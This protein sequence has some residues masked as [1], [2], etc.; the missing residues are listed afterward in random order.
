MYVERLCWNPVAELIPEK[1]MQKIQWKKLKYMLNYVYRNS[2]YYNRVFREKG[3]H[4][5]DINSFD[6]FYKK[7]PLTYKEDLRAMQ[8]ESYP[9]G[10]NMCVPYSEV[11][12][13]TASTGTTGKPTYTGFT[14]HDWEINKEC[15]KRTFWLAGLRPGDVY[16]HALALSNWISGVAVVEAG[17]EMGLVVLPIGVPT[18]A[19]R[20][21]TMILDQHPNAMTCTPSYALHL[22]D[23]VRELLNKDPK[24][25]GIRKM[26]C[27][28][29]PG[30]GI[31]SIRKR[32]EEAWGADVRDVMGTPEQISA[33]WA[34]CQYKCGMHFVAR[35]FVLNELVDPETK[36]HIEWG[37]GVEG[38][39]VYT[40]LDRECAPLIR[41]YVA[42]QV[43]AFTEKCECGYP[44]Y[45]ITVIGRYDDML[46]IKGVKTWPSAI[47]DV[48]STLTPRVTG[49]FR[50]VLSQKPV[51]FTVSGPIKLVVEHGPGVKPEEFPKL[52]KEIIDKIASALYWTPDEV[53]LVP[54]GT[55]PR[56]EFKARYMEIKA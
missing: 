39:L 16:L 4:P 24:E 19:Q 52:K 2:Q 38:A 43:K 35:E 40:A 29:E 37:E 44:S 32:I 51:A 33:D 23:R 13:I 48:L 11:R 3:I 36:E 1:E 21:I 8:K 28:G 9:F 34:E 5:E 50:L 14:Q 22:A 12:V 6:D 49:E 10:S 45:R 55:L 15:I 20:M 25:L 47:A 7:V 30:A 31:P 53:E 54:P 17:H 41:F 27:G 46:K 26:G 42:D 18:P 56:P